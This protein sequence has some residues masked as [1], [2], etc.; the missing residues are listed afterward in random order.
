MLFLSV[1][2]A[3]FSQKPLVFEGSQVRGPLLERGLG[4][5]IIM[6]LKMSCCI[7]RLNRFFGTVSGHPCDDSDDHHSASGRDHGRSEKRSSKIAEDPRGKIAHGF[8]QI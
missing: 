1:F 4:A 7:I 5:C 3:K 8:G 6:N 2:D